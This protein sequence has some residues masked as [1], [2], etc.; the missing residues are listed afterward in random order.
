MNSHIFRSPEYSWVINIW[1]FITLEYVHEQVHL[2]CWYVQGHSHTCPIQPT[3]IQNSTAD[4]HGGT[5][6]PLEP[7]SN[8]EIHELIQFTR[9]MKD[10]LAHLIHNSD[11]ECSWK[12]F[13]YWH[14]PNDDSFFLRKFLK[15]F[16]HL[17]FMC[18]NML[19]TVPL[20]HF[21]YITA[22]SPK[23]PWTLFLP[24]KAWTGKKKVTAICHFLGIGIIYVPCLRST[25][26]P[27]GRQVT[28][29]P[30]KNLLKRRLT[31]SNSEITRLLVGRKRTSYRT[32]KKKVKQTSSNL[33]VDLQLLVIFVLIPNVKT[34][35]I[36]LLAYI[37]S[38]CCSWRLE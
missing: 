9:P 22:S 32:K 28:L 30:A 25:L 21:M 10:I 1:K 33:T 2:L 16:W 15:F 26:T 11:T 17:L 7:H 27:V 6:E 35:W 18:I 4:G 37:E 34:F 12:K 31:V 8:T 29:L 5:F 20:F 19:R 13:R 24:F 23:M 3:R 38:I 14:C 36:P